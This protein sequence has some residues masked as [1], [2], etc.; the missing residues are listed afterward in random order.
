M[1]TIINA[2][3]ERHDRFEKHGI[4][5]TWGDLHIGL[6]MA[7]AQDWHDDRQALLDIIRE[8]GESIGMQKDYLHPD[9]FVLAKIKVTL[10]R[11]EP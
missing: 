2:I 9:S 11:T 8:I 10:N 5:K 1:K 3:Q 4:E 7:R 6:I